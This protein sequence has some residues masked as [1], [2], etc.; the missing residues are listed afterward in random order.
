MS[1]DEHTGVSE[2]GGIPYTYEH[3]EGELTAVG[4]LYRITS[5]PDLVDRPPHRNI[6]FVPGRQL[7][8][9][10]RESPERIVD[11]R[12]TTPAAAREHLSEYG[13]DPEEIDLGLDSSKPAEDHDG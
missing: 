4:S 9:F 10:L 5:T 3:A 2:A 1:D 13:A 12:P 11:I 7:D 6:Y 8:Q